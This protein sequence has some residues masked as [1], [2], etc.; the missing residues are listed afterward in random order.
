MPLSTKTL[1]HEKINYPLE[2]LPEKGEI[3]QVVEGVFWIRMPLFFSLDHIN[4]WLLDDGDGW[5]LVDTSIHTKDMVEI[6][7]M[8]IEKYCQNKPIKKVICTHMHPDHVGMAGWIVERFGCA[9]L[10]TRLEYLTCRV[11]AADTGRPAPP[12]GISFY[13]QHA[14]PEHFVENYKK[15]FGSFGKVIYAMPQSYQRL[16][17]ADILTIG[18]RQWEIVVG[19][20][21]SPEHASLYCKDLDVFITGDQV[22][23]KISSHIGTFPTEPDADNLSDW[24]DSCAK[25]KERVPD[26]VLVLPAHNTPFYG[27]HVRLQKLIESHEK[28][29][30]RILKLL[31]TPRNAN[32]S[33]L[34]SNLFKRKIDDTNL[35]MALSETLSHLNCLMKR[36]LIERRQDE[37]GI[38]WYH[39]VR[40]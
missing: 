33:D 23:P 1:I 13:Q 31:S 30:S 27:L 4:L 40:S 16:D 39:A 26:T 2:A 15:L 28:A 29:L 5:I 18:G 12:E 3:K 21:H 37:N 11:L 14:M 8:L 9:L 17:D 7:E 24:L 20:G 38:L 32:D 19:N 34:F 22:L 36:G 6:W 35:G 25:L 10:M